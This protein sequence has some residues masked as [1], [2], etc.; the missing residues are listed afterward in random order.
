[1]LIYIYQLAG[2][3]LKKIVVNSF[4]MID[5]EIIHIFHNCFVLK[6]ETTVFVFD[7]PAAR[8]RR[9]SHFKSLKQAIKGED[10][11]VFI[12]HSHT[13]HFDPE[14]RETCS[15]AKSLKIIV[16][17]D[18]IDMFPNFC[19]EDVKVVEPDSLYNFNGF[20][21]KTLMSNDLGV[22]FI[23]GLEVGLNIYFGGDLALWD[24]DNSSEAEKKFVR[25]FF[26]ESLAKISKQKIH[27]AFSNLDKR[28]ESLA[29]GPDF[30][31]YVEPDVFIPTH[32]FGRTGWL[33]GIESRLGISRKKCFI[34]RK[35][36]ESAVFKM[37]E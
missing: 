10:I 36:G 26:Y 34:Y 31:K 13:D 19:G 20:K 9:K 28:L 35:T 2:L 21:L 7:V 5:V 14:L 33:E 24:W 18:V 6:T 23:I 4:I 30:I 3:F 17:D 12:S 15:A 22:A 16:A 27:I 29:G 32:V 11:T 1:M 37:L 8:F 25:N